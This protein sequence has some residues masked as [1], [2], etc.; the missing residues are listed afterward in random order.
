VLLQT[1]TA[2]SFLSPALFFLFFF[3]SLLS[4]S[5]IW[6]LASTFGMDF[7][8][9]TFRTEALFLTFSFSFGH[10]GHYFCC[11]GP[12]PTTHVVCG[13]CLID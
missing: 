5:D 9:Y 7:T 12:P 13:F 4:L 11:C 10:R 8:L 1:L 3:F 2:V 6:L